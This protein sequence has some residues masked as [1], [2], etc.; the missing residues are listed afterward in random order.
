MNVKRFAWL[1][2]ARGLAQAPH[3]MFAA[4][5][6][7][8]TLYWPIVH[9]EQLVQAVDPLSENWP[10]EQAEHAAE[11]LAPRAVENVPEEQE[12][13]TLA[14]ADENVPAAQKELQ[15]VELVSPVPEEK[16][17]AAHA[18]QFCAPSARQPPKKPA[19]HG[20]GHAR[21]IMVSPVSVYRAATSAAVRA[22]W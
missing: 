15:A 7:L 18:L 3:T 11:V 8:D 6:Q 5:W 16:V 19:G 17:P 14:A 1:D 21:M 9:V 10:A 2:L 22:L 13:Q 12:L 4:G 20:C